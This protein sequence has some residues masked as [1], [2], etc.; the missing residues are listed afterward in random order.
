MIQTSD[1]RVQRILDEQKRVQHMRGARRM[2]EDDAWAML[3]KIKRGQGAEYLA[4]GAELTGMKAAEILRADVW[5]GQRCFILGGGDSLAGFDFSRLK[6]ERVIA[7]NR[8]FEKAPFADI[9]FA[10]DSRFYWWTVRGELPPDKNGLGGGQEAARKFAAFEGLKVWLDL[11]GGKALP[12]VAFLSSRGTD[13]VPGELRDGIYDG[14]NSGYAALNL[15]IALGANPIYLLGFDMHGD[16]AGHQAWFHGGYPTNQGDRVYQGFASHFEKIAPALDARGIKV[17]NLNP[18]SSLRCFEF[19]R[20]EDLSKQPA[21]R[22]T[23]ITPTGDRPLALSLLRRWVE[24]QTRQPDQWIIVDDGREPIKLTDVP[25]WAALVRREP[26]PG[27]PPH[28]LS[29]NLAAAIPHITGERILILEDDEYYAPRYIEEMT[30]RL[31]THDVVGICKNKYYHVGTGG[32][33]MH[34]NLGHASLAQTGV[35]SSF[36]PELREL[37]AELSRDFLDIRIWKR[38]ERT[39][40]GNLFLD[41]ADPL[42]L[43]IKGLPGRPG[44]GVGHVGQRYALFDGPGRDQLRKWI[45]DPEAQSAYLEIIEGTNELNHV[46]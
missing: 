13:G 41:G 8:A 35:R 34:P 33:C 27:D 32:Y 26:V 3:K 2:S 21:E 44:I 5:R 29:V 10:F 18:G 25:D 12:G 42:Y 39:G 4:P 11:T 19:G 17:V 6:G 38:V 23:A 45:P 46:R 28:T 43:G 30:A 7:I 9:L 37:V 24:K 14:G 40:R 22:V 15:A 31:A 1:P 16:G 20:F 36:L